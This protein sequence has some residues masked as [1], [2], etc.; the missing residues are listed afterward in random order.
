MSVHRW[1]HLANGVY[2]G[3]KQGRHF[4]TNKTLKLEEGRWALWSP[5][6]I[7]F[8]SRLSWLLV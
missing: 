6:L 4:P 1:S 8:P 5:S 3:V 2:R 7:S